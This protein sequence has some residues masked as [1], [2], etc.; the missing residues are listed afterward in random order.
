M[1]TLT[2]VVVSNKMDKT[3]IVSVERFWEHPKYKK[4]LNRHSKFFVH[5]EEK[6]KEGKKIKI[7]ETK[8]VSKNKTWKVLE[9][10]K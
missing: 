4:R 6:I 9:I 3:I 8:P 5:T 2:G 7:G 10:L 1:K